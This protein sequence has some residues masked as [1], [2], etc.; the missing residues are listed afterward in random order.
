MGNNLSS[1]QDN[2]QKYSIENDNKNKNNIK[3]KKN[4]NQ[5]GVTG[6]K[7]KKNEDKISEIEENPF[8]FQF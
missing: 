7:K 2:Q 1:Q 6:L 5:K 8:F 4:L 3:D